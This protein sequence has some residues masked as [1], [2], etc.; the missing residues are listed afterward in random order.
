MV[1]LYH[2]TSVQNLES[3]LTLGGSFY[4]TIGYYNQ[5]IAGFYFTDLP[6]ETNNTD[7]QGALFG[8]IT[9]RTNPAVSAQAYLYLG[10]D[11]RELKKGG[12]EHVYY[13]LKTSP[14]L[15]FQLIEFGRRKGW[16][17][18]GKPSREIF[19][20]TPYHKYFKAKQRFAE[21]KCY[22]QGLKRN[23]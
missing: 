16:Q 19:D 15:V 11:G 20:I 18:Y 14:N 12:R 17:I 8:R 22:L 2:Y 10:V 1:N 21:G 5:N 9:T 23:V 7:L 13:L 6:P 4:N 3:I